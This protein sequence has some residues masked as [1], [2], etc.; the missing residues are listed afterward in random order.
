MKKEQIQELFEQF[1]S[2]CY[3]YKSIE[4]RSARELQ[5]LLGYTKWDNFLN[6]LKRQKKRVKMPVVLFPII[7]PVSGK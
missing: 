7:L 6:K 4:C 3:I 2:A 1:E 5:N